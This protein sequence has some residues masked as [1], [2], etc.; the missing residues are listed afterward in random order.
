MALNQASQRPAHVHTSGQT[1]TAIRRPTGSSG[2]SMWDAVASVAPRPVAPANG[3]KWR[4]NSI[5]IL[6]IGAGALEY[7]GGVAALTVNG[8]LRMI[9]L[10]CDFED[11]SVL[12]Q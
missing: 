10:E 9:V 6:Q 2:L 4:G 12:F 11:G 3:I 1:N 7:C 8:G 5:S